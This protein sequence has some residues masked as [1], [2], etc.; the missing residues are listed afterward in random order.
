MS[1]L[2]TGKVDTLQIQPLVTHKG[3]S[4]RRTTLTSFQTMLQTEQTEN[5]AASGETDSTESSQCYSGVTFRDPVTGQ[6]VR[7]IEAGSEEDTASTTGKASAKSSSA[8]ST[9]KSSSGSQTTSASSMKT[10]PYDT[11][12]KK[13]AKKYGVSESLLKGIAKA[14]SNFNARDLSSSGAM[15]VMQLMPETARSLGVDDPYDPEQNILGGAKCIAQKL[16]EFNGDVK[17][18]LAAYN[19]GSGAVKRAGGIPSQ[20]KSYVNKV[21]SYQEAYETA[22]KVG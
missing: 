17:L 14:E 4:G 6:A 16:K 9:S 7:Y 18:A 21:L 2:A 13:A 5:S 8:S 19:A 11:Y 15:G 10:T 20:C 3:E 1:Y 12:F 22:K